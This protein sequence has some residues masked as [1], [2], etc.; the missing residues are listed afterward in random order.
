MHL[1]RRTATVVAVAA[2]LAAGGFGVPARAA[3]S[4][5]AITKVSPFGPASD[6]VI[7]DPGTTVAYLVQP[8]GHVMVG[9]NNVVPDAQAREVAISA[10]GGVIAF[11]TAKSLVGGDANGASD[12]YAVNSDGS[13]LRLV[14]LALPAM[15]AYSPSVNG[16]GSSITYSAGATAPGARRE[17]Y[18][19]D[20]G[21]A[22]IPVAAP[23]VNCDCIRPSISNDGNSI[24]FEVTDAGIF[25]WQRNGGATLVPGS[26]KGS[27]LPEMSGSGRM[28]AYQRAERV[29][30]FN[31]DSGNTTQ[32]AVPGTNPSI[33]A[34][35]RTV[36]YQATTPFGAD[37]N[38]QSDIVTFDVVSG[39]THLVSAT[40][41]GTV[42]GGSYQPSI[43]SDGGR[44]AFESEASGLVGG[45]GNGVT[46]IYLRIPGDGGVAPPCCTGGP[47]PLDDTPDIPGVYWLVGADGGIFSFGGLGEAPRFYGSTGDIRLNK[48]VV[49]MTPTPS[50]RG[51]WFVATDG[52]I[53]SYGDAKFFG[54]TGAMTLN[55]PIVGMASTPS[56]NGYWLVATDGGIF[57]F[58]DA[59]FMGSTGD[60]KLNRP[61]IGMM[62]RPQGDGYWMIAD[63]GGVFSFGNAPFKGST[64]AMRLP[65]PIVGI[66]RT[67]TGNG[68]WFTGADGAVFG[69]GDAGHFGAMNHIRLN[70]PIV[71][72]AASH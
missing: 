18:V 58:G 38:G 14:S 49:G 16:D 37:G 5:G 2:L 52:G 50:G 6:P 56:G 63:D 21:G 69:F 33:S 35:G 17:V 25:V 65:A 13:N 40:G 43:N 44:V 27:G 24:A 55:K 7:D 68:Y 22:P 34:D 29:V 48:P 31:R 15:G 28:V 53:F 61:I 64:G 54:S 20:G 1:R 19:R 46:D 59:R 9:G 72:M 57:S 26:G 47:G 23:G 10:N 12:V 41:A 39:Q 66:S 4:N 67:R 8:A 45:D 42:A 51:Y 71:G 36:A 11:A 70:R 60:I 3:V 32:T 62:S 30:V